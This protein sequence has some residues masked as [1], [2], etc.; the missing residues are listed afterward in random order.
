MI[1]IRKPLSF[2]EIGQKD[3]QEDYLYPAVA[4][5]RSR[6]FLLCDGMGGHEKGEVASKTAA[7]AMGD[8]LSS[9]GEVNEEEIQNALTRAYDALDRIECTEGK[10]KPGTTMTCLCIESDYCMAAHIGDS[11]IYQIRPSLF[12]DADGH[13][14]IVYQS[15]DHSLVNDL[16]K[17]GEITEEEAKNYKH[18]N[19]ITKAMQP[20]L[21]IRHKGEVK[22]LNDVKAGDYFFLCSDGVLEHLTNVGLCRILSDKSMSDSE[23]L[24]SIK[25]ACG[26]TTRDNHS[27]WLIPVENIITAKK[28]RTG[29]EMARKETMWTYLPYVVIGIAVAAIIIWIIL[30]LTKVL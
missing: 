27:C 5:S 3:N 29:N 2:S 12:N 21:Q 30:K 23:K 17:I 4:D 15:T 22:R 13:G 11:R 6:V 7:D 28:E 24:E 10:K 19:I 8:Y 25:S 20:Q 26:D 16:L 9:C 1:E 18:K 14:G